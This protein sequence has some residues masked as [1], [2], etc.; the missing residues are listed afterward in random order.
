VDNRLA[1]RLWLAVALAGDALAPSMLPA[2]AS[3]MLPAKASAMLPRPWALL[4]A[5]LLGVGLGTPLVAAGLLV[6]G[7]SMAMAGTDHAMTIYAP[8]L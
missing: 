8:L 7:T 3:A 4:A 2:T 5:A 6:A 1:V